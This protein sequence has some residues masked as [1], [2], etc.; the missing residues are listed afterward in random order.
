MQLQTAYLVTLAPNKSD[1]FEAKLSSGKAASTMRTPS[2]RGLFAAVGNQLSSREKASASL[3]ELNEDRLPGETLAS[4]AIPKERH[5][6]LVAMV[7]DEIDN[8]MAAHPDHTALSIGM[9]K[10]GLGCNHAFEPIGHK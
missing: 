2:I 6:T 10:H 4:K 5:R 3:T 9:A 7:R 1:M 8:S